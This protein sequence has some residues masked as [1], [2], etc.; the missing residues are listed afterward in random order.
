MKR[1]F[2]GVFCA[3]V[4]ITGCSKSVKITNGEE[5]IASI[6]GRDFTAN[7]LYNSMKDQYGTSILINL[8]DSYIANKEIPEDDDANTYADSLVS[9][10][11]LQFEQNK[12]DFNK[13]LLSAGYESVDAFKKVLAEEYKKTEVIKKYVKDEITDKEIQKYYDEKISEE[14]NVKHILIKPDVDKSASEEE[15]TEAETVAYNKAADIISKLND[16]K[17]FEELAKEYSA[18]EATASNGGVINNVTKDGFVSEFYDAAYALEAGKYTTTPVKTTYGYH[19]IYLVS[20][21]DKEPLENLKD[22]IKDSIVTDK[23][24]NDADLQK[25][26]LEKIRKKYNLSIADSKL[27]NI[28]KS[29]LEK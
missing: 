25:N 18:D 3:L 29:S 14:L 23:L 15:K 24:E 19:I 6:D 11:K 8:V 12:S 21:N 5:V 4:L 2:L 10:Y 20:K 13:A 16:G 17:D 28:Y 1:K 9:Q 7:E 22:T 26:T 27:D